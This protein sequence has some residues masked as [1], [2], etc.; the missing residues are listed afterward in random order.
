MSKDKIGIQLYTLRDSCKDVETFDKTCAWIESQ[1]V[2]DVV[3]V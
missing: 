3:D 1:R 2:S